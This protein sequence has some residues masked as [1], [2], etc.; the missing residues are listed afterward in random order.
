MDYKY[1]FAWII[2]TAI[3]SCFLCMCFNYRVA[4]ITAFVIWIVIGVM[5]ATKEK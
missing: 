5:A 1:V 2:V 3:I 4:A